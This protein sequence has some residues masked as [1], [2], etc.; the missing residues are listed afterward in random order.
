MRGAVDLC[1]KTKSGASQDEMDG[2]VRIHP[3]ALAEGLK[4][5]MLGEARALP[6]VSRPSVIFFGVEHDRAPNLPPL[7]AIFPDQLTRLDPLARLYS[8]E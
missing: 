3:P 4:L 7:P 2:T 1:A 8:H 6:R 5:A